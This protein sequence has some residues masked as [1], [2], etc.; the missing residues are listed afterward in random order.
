MNSRH[1]LWMMEPLALAELESRLRLLAAGEAKQVAA[2]REAARTS[3]NVVAVIPIVGVMEQRLSIWSDYYGGTST[4]GIAKVFSAAVSDAS[5]KAIMLD[6]SSPGG[7]VYGVP[8][9]ARRIYDARGTKPI[10]AVANSMAASAAYYV[11]VAADRLYVTPSGDVGS[12]GVYQ[13]HV[14]YS[15]ALEAEGVAVSFIKAPAHKAEGNPYE[16]LSDEA[17]EYLQGEVNELYEM[18]VAD[19]AKYRGTKASAVKAN[20]GEGRTLSARKAVAAGMADG[21]AT[22]DQVAAKL[23]A[24]HIKT[25]G[26]AASD[27]WE[28]PIV[29]DD[30]A[31]VRHRKAKI[32]VAVRNRG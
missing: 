10:V 12:V 15:K 13:M 9:L 27:D 16:P 23:L 21:V 31:A 20:F 2:P 28:S 3:G 29:A 1:S 25:T 19:V 26:P 24:G 11:G 4:D 30:E 18:F 14:D 7:E 8:E 32:A 6:I 17:R 22:F 5:V